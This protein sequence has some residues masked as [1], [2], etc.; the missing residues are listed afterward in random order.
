MNVLITGGYGF[1]GSHVAEEFFREGHRIFIIDNL[2]TGNLKNIKFKHTSFRMDIED[3]RCREVFRSNK[4]DVVVHLAAQ[5]NVVSSIKDPYQDTSSNILG[6]TNMLQLSAQYGVRK[7]VFASS[8]AIYGNKTDIPLDEDDLPDPIS[9]YG[10][11][12]ATG[13][14]YCRKWSQLYGLSTICFRFSNVYGPRQGVIGEGGVISIFMERAVQGKELVVFGDGS[15]TRDFIYVKDI[16]AGIYKAVEKNIDGVYNLSTNTGSSVNQLVEV[17]RGLQPVSGVIYRE[18]REGDIRDSRLDNTKLRVAL[19]WKPSCCFAEG[20]KRTYS[21][22]LDYYK[23]R[24]RENNSEGTHSKKASVWRHLSSRLQKSGLLYCIEN[25]LLFFM[26]GFMT[27]TSQNTSN[28][29]MIDYKLVYIVFAGLRYGIKQA[30][31]AAVLSCGLFI[32]L[33][34]EGGRDIYV[35]AYDT[36]SL[37]QLSIYLLAGIVAGYIIDTKK[38]ELKERDGEIQAL[39]EKV[40]FMNKIHEE[41][42]LIK[43]ELCDQIIS[44]QDSYG[45]VYQIITRLNCLN[46]KEVLAN[47]VQV[48]EDVLKSQTVAIYTL[49]VSKHHAILAAKSDRKEFNPPA[50][51]RV[52][53]REDLQLVMKTKEIYV[54]Y[55]WQPFMPVMSAP[56][57]DRGDMVAVACVYSMEF[58]NITQ[59]RRNMLKVTV[60][61]I[62]YALSNA[63]RYSEA[64]ESEFID[65]MAAAEAGPHVIESDRIP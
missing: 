60:N 58:E 57:I 63:F 20:L 44:A 2:S 11:S 61:L 30:A 5:I 17:L 28:E 42:L 45:K 24:P 47:G 23:S 54:N 31:M 38:N 35:L 52:R 13:E 7:F 43:D 40:D 51:F 25:L 1:I 50:I 4:F 6:L 37:L 59:Y 18:E 62:S 32:F 3:S 21:W 26:V 55:E 56:I 33:Y 39:N 41:T 64:T 8:A 29:Y 14:L 27:I 46:P 36:N 53:D 10:M 19:D 15:Q 22:Y 9:P 16:A 34:I 12:K 65:Y 49:S 48:I